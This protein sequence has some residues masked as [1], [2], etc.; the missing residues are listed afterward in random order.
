VSKV[1]AIL[2]CVA[3]TNDVQIAG[4]SL[5]DR[6]IV[7]VHRAGCAPIC[8]ITETGPATPRARA[9]GINITLASAIP[10]LDEPALLIN[11]GV[12]VETADLQ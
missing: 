12:L 2:D 4:L 9:L 8:L 1:T 6:L 3:E 10:E 11:G 5:L 7:T